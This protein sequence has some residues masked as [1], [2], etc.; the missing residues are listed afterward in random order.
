KYSNFI[1]EQCKVV[2]NMMI[3]QNLKLK[4][5]NNQK[6]INKILQKDP[7]EIVFKQAPHII[8]FENKKNYFKLEIIN[9]RNQNN[10]HIKRKKIKVKRS[11]IFEDSFQQIHNLKS[12][13]LKHKFVIEFEGEEGIDAGGLLREW[14]TLLSKAIFNPDYL[15]FKLSSN[16]NTYQ[17]N[18]NSYINDNHLEYFKFVGRIVGK[19]LFEGQMLDAYFTRSF[20]KHILGQPLTYHDIEDQDQEFYKNLKWVIETDISQF[21]DLTFSFEENEFDN[22]QVIELIQNGR[23]ISVTEENKHEYVKLMCYTKMARNIKIQIEKFLEGFHE[24]IPHEYIKIFDSHELELMISGLPEI[25]IQDLKENSEYQNYTPNSK[26]I[27][28][29]WEILESFDQTERASF[30]QFVTGTSKVPLEGFKQLRGYSGLQKF[31][32]H[33]SYDIRKL[34][35]AHTCFNQLDIPEYPLKEILKKKL[36]LAILEGKEGFGFA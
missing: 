1:C 27:K 25:D 9:L 21:T 11:Q 24:L 13:E 19:A 34:P 26:I 2:I 32:I 5:Q 4:R 18:Q 15:L 35:V 8:D 23:N 12:E 16:G 36:L 7:F 3:R 14:F 17:P 22:Y 31:Q 30:L 28:W 20:Y 33:K 10:A 29:F 6:K